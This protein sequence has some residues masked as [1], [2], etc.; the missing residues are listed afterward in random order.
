[1]AT[2]H[3]TTPTYREFESRS[4]EE[5]FDEVLERTWK[6]ETVIGE[7]GHPFAVRALMVAGDL[8]LTVA[9]ETRHLRAGDTFELDRDQ[10]H[11]ER[12]GSEGATFW[13]ARRNAAGPAAS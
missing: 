11:A 13:V 10:P 7:H 1:M 12:Y 3:I 9:D 8:W 5:G 2:P 4:H 6:P